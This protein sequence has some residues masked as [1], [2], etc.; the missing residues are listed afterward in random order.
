MSKNTLPKTKTGIMQAIV[1]RCV[2]RECLQAKGEKAVGTVK[3]VLLDLG[4]LAWKAL[5]ESGKKLLFDR[6]STARD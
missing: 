4:K 2:D 5:N 3:Q 6:V 1:D